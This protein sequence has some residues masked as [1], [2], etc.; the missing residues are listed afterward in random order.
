MSNTDPFAPDASGATL[1]AIVK[2]LERRWGVT[3]VSFLPE[4][5]EQVHAVQLQR[6]I[7]KLWNGQAEDSM[8]QGRLYIEFYEP[9]H[10][11]CTH[12]TLTRSDPSGPV[13]ADSFTKE[14][15]RQFELFEIIH[16]ATSQTQPIEVA[17]DRLSIAHD[18]LGIVLFGECVGEDAARYRRTLLENL[19]SAL[20]ASFNLSPRPWDKD[21]SEFH[22]L[23]CSLGYLKRPVPQGYSAFVD[24]IKRIEFAPLSFTLED[25]ALVHHRYRTLAPP[26]EGGITFPL[27][28]E[29]DLTEDEFV[30][31]LN[32]T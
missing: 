6:E 9:H 29:V 11:H 21:H 12:F 1:S 26:Q 14:D 15:H 30:R 5:Q 24:E 25:V 3:L 4:T 2:N 23:H 13:K 10:F 8:R 28:K 18:R 32:L 22:K 17:F 31:K 27:G 16:G 7:S 19:N 20:P